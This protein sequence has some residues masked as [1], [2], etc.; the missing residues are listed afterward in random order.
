MFWLCLFGW[1]FGW[2]DLMCWSVCVGC[3]VMCLV[4][5]CCCLVLVCSW[6]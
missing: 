1:M 3:Y 5:W 6:C 4:C 2:V